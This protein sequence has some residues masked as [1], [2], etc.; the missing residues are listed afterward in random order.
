MRKKVSFI[1]VVVM[2][3][4]AWLF[5]GP[6]EV[7]GQTQE[8]LGN[9]GKP[10]EDAYLIQDQLS[11]PEPIGVFN[12]TNWYISGNLGVGTDTPGDNIDLTAS[13]YPFMRIA[14]TGTGNAGLYIENPTTGLNSAIIYLN[15]DANLRLAS[16]TGGSIR[17]LTLERLTG[18]LGIQTSAPQADL[19]IGQLSLAASP[20]LRMSAS[21]GAASR[22][23]NLRFVE[24]GSGTP[25]GQLI[26]DVAVGRFVF[27][28]CSACGGDFT[29]RK[30]VDSGNAADVVLTANSLGN[31]ALGGTTVQP[32]AKVTINGNV[33]VNGNVTKTGVG[34][35]VR[36]K[37]GERE[38]EYSVSVGP[39]VGTYVRGTAN[40]ENGKAVIELP[41][42]FAAVTSK[43]GL[44]VQLTLL[45]D[46]NGLR[47]VETGAKRIVVS[48]LMGGSS[49][50][51]FYY[52]VQGIRNGQENHQVVYAR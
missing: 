17:G 13:S 3:F 51:K 10:L 46:C 42:H 40:L 24:E 35:L 1:L 27:D 2:V 16:N 32:G 36:I 37:D 47:V 9:N 4:S 20:Q 50:A 33:H 15:D 39:E 28:Y 23:P 21:A 26:S 14:T 29:I 5:F 34:E 18:R 8:E 6:R 7:R 49:N 31:M 44:T 30:T 11:F 52:L 48:E 12:T 22:F 43:E 45:D 41:E 25:V 38:L 19:H